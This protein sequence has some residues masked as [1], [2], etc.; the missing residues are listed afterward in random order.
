MKIA[1]PPRISECTVNFHIRNAMA[2]PNAGNKTDAALPWR[3][4]PS[5]GLWYANATFAVRKWRDIQKDLSYK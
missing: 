1:E 2:K 4:L 5:S 3:H